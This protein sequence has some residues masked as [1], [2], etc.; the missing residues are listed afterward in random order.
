MTDEP[1]DDPSPGGSC[2]GSAAVWLMGAVLP[3]SDANRLA[4]MLV[5]CFGPQDAAVSLSITGP[6]ELRLQAYFDG[7]LDR[8]AIRELV[9]MAVGEPAAASM[10]FEPLMARDWVS[11]S[12][13]G[14]TP[15]RAGR[16]FVHGAHDRERVSANALGIEVEAALAFGTGHHGTTRGCLLALD[17]LAKA[18]RSRRILD[19]GTGTGV[20]AIAAAA[21]LRVP[22]LASDID[23]AAVAIARSN[24]HANGQGRRVETLRAAGLGARRIRE[25][26]PYDLVFANILLRPLQRLAQP[27]AGVLAP[28]GRVILSGLLSSQANAAIAAYRA[29]GLRLLHR[30][31]LEGWTTLIMRR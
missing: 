28:G 5:E 23:G 8:A 25:R 15:V 12:L 1:A 17:R 9:R 30:I 16:F 19:V 22:V 6:Q 10:V 21:L 13:A 24:A 4:S 11:E 27:I 20:L 3:E 2:S 7:A 29:Q 26:A 31:E 14:L 18:E